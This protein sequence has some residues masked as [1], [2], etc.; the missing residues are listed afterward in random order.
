[1]K[2][3]ISGAMRRSQPFALIF[4]TLSFIVVMTGCKKENLTPAL[5]EEEFQTRSNQQ[6]ESNGFGNYTGLDPKTVGELQQAKIATARYNDFQQAINDGYVDINV[7]VPEMGYHYLKMDNLD[8]TFDYAKPEILVY[9][10]E[11]NGRMKLVALEY[12]TPLSATP[13]AGFTGDQ[14]VWSVYQ[15]VLWTLHAWIWEYNPAGVFNPTNPLIHL[16]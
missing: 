6:K 16:H 8:G 14:D 2:R 7:I 13:P 15:G 9:N 10:K 3:L 1:M 4:L 12:A 5:N 11:E